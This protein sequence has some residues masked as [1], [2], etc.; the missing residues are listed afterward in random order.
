MAQVLHTGDT[1]IGY[2]QY[3]SPERRR[4]FLRAFERVIDDAVDLGVD[5]V[6]H[7]GDLFQDR[8]P[9]LTDLQV[10]L[11][12]LRRLRAAD[13]PFLA[14]VGNHED[15]RDQQWLDLLADLGYAERLG[16][17]PR[18]VG[19]LALYGLDY[20][21][22]SVRGDLDYEFA[23]TD[24]EYTALVA[25]GL[26]EPFDAGDWDPREILEATSIEFDAMLLGDNH[27]PGKRRVEGTWLTYPGSTER[28]SASE[29]AE[30]GYNLV[31][32]DGELQISRRTIPTRPFEFVD[33]TLEADE[34]AEVVRRRVREHDLEDAVVIVTI[35]G[36]G[37]TITPG[38]IEE[39]AREEGALIAR[40]NDRREFEETASEQTVTFAD[41]DAAVRNRVEQLGLSP[42]AREIDQTV[43]DE[44]VADSNVREVIRARIDAHLEDGL[45]GLQVA[46]TDEQET[47]TTPASSG[48]ASME[49]F[50]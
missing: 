27:T 42:V 24:A 30:R 29:R 28:A 31:R 20:I 15:K 47:D 16:E 9:D 44:T 23:S 3:H 25:H 48:Q 32:T 5:A 13:I 8:R 46:P 37:T 14:V 11:G 50:L 7:A 38:P 36:E 34:G 1:H 6:V 10:V 12:A 45:D 40:V 33:V 19:N 17:Q 18:V 2:Q 43:R 4:D 21:P 35:E 49:E 26:F 39:L 22:P 41:P